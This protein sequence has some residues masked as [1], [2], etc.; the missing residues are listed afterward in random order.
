[1]NVKL[2]NEIEHKV[3]AEPSEHIKFIKVIGKTITGAIML[4][5]YCEK[6]TD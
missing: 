2:Y 5:H 4:Q 3:K 6:S 1:M